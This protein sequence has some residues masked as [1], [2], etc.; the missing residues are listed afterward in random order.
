[1]SMKRSIFYLVIR[2]RRF[3]NQSFL[4]QKKS[5]FEDFVG[6]LEIEG[7]ATEK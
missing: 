2:N 6:Y 3:R 5:F 1:M 7:K 4:I